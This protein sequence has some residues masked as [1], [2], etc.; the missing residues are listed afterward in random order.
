MFCINCVLFVSQENRKNLNTFVNFGC[1]DWHN[2]IE[3]Q[4]I[5]VEQKYHKDA[6]KDSHDL[7]NCFEKPEGTIEYHL[8]TFYHEKCNKY[9]K[10]A[11]TIHFH[12]SKD[13]ALRGH[14][15]TLQESDENQNL[16]RFLTYLKELQNYC[17]ELKEHLGAS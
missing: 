6:I 4:S 14:K 12:G 13:L 9:P 16:G 10:F 11:R 2:I 8:D 5:H 17:P 1:S 3:R 7:I 15:E